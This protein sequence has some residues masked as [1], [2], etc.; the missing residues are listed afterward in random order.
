MKGNIYQNKIRK[1][2]K[3]SKQPKCLYNDFQNPMFQSMFDIK[4]K[5]LKMSVSSKK[6]NVLNF[7]MFSR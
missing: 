4:A 7:E 2:H 5:E 1:L 3:V 6:G